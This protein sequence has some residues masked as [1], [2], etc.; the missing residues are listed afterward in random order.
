MSLVKR[1]EEGGE[2][3]AK[4]RTCCPSPVVKWSFNNALAL[5]KR[6]GGVTEQIIGSFVTTSGR[7]DRE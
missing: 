2:R 7:L 5:C 3:M 4:T 1:G 6:S